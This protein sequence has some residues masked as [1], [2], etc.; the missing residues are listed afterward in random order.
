MTD[1]VIILVTT[2]NVIEARKISKILVE[3]KLAACCNIVEK[4]NSI[5]FWQNNVVDDFES[6]I[7]IKTRK[8]LFPE[9][10]ARVKELHKYT[11]PEIIAI[12]IIAGSNSYLDWINDTVKQVE[13]TK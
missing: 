2:P 9:L 7:I 1:Y 11:V 5:Y 3:E 4:V 10:E 13:K 12:P 6:L 8:D